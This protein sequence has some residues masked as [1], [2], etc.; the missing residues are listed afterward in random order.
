M[1]R[2]DSSGTCAG[3]GRHA[4]PGPH[5]KKGMREQAQHENQGQMD[6]LVICAKVC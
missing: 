1:K 2:D 4:N 3:A 5:A 6:S